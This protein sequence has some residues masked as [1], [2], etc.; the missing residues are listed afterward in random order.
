LA[1]H[2]WYL[3]YGGGL[4]D[5]IY[6]FLRCRGAWR[7]G[8]L[9]EM[10]QADI[11]VYTLCHND[12][13]LDTFKNSPFIKYHIQ[14]PWHPPCPEDHVRFNNEIDGYKPLQHDAFFFSEYGAGLP[15]SEP[16]L[17]LS[18]QEKAELAGLMSGRPLIV[19][20]PYAGLS[21]RDGFDSAAF[22]R[23][24]TET[25]ALEPRVRFVVVG[26]NHERGHKYAREELLFSHPNV[27]NLI[28]K[29]GIR[30]CFHLV[31]NCD[32]FVGCHSNL[33]RTAW[34]FRRR[35]VCVL[36]DPLMTSHLQHLDGKYTYGFKY[37]ESHTITYPF[38]TGGQ[39]HFEMMDCKLMAAYLLG[40]A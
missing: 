8:P 39:R 1:Q 21:D 2:Q 7:M 32:A 37:P 34:D 11:R 16:K 5:V 3:T 18:P 27:V 13:V 15:Q 10:Y 33:I 38:A 40:R 20:Q 25:T 23:L 29:A 30:F 9:V 31:A 17:Y 28:D 12:G 6:D 14:E 22:E 19:A 35:N 4:G 26:K 36:P 24:V